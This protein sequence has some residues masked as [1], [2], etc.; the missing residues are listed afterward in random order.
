[1][2]NRDVLIPIIT[3]IGEDHR[4]RKIVSTLKRYGYTP[5]VYCDAPVTPYKPMWK[6]IDLSVITRWSHTRCFLPVFILFNLKLVFIMSISRAGVCIVEDCP[7]LLTASLIGRIKGIRVIYDSHELFSETPGVKRGVVRRFFWR[8]W[9]SA[10][11]RLS[12]GVITVSEGIKSVLAE[13]FPEKR[14][15]VLPNMPLYT[16]R[17]YRKDPELSEKSIRLLYQGALRKGSG[18]MDALKGIRGKERISIDIF[19]S[20][21][22]EAALREYACDY[23]MQERVRFRGVIESSELALKTPCYDIGLHLLHPLN[24]SFDL[25][26]SNKIFEYLQAG[27]PVLL[28]NTNAHKELL[29][30]YPV[31][32]VVPYGDPDSIERGLIALIKEYPFY[33]S[34]VLAHRRVLCWGNY[35]EVLIKEIQREGK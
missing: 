17:E 22:E 31:G 6:D 5:H 21:E 32:I 14:I 33:H 28:S 1:M 27:L 4:C 12:K 7:P 8:V 26:L 30:R 3:N 19:G 29:E 20:G 13:R 34:R 2:N 18:L 15:Q 10:G 11:I 35:E 9:E 16:A 24:R 23:G 25:T